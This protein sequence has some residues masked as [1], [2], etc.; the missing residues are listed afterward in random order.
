MWK[1]PT[2]HAKFDLVKN[3]PQ[4]FEKRPPG[5]VA[6]CSHVASCDDV[7]A[8]AVHFNEQGESDQE[9]MLIPLLAKTRSGELASSRS[10]FG[11]LT[12]TTN[13]KNILFCKN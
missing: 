11:E 5:S 10:G 6:S 3:R 7:L 1:G 2:C 4:T 8:K 13:G 12:A 9:L